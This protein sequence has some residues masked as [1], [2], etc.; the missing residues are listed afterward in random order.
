MKI[1]LMDL[2]AQYMSL[3]S[4][5]KDAVCRV[6]DSGK[7][8]LGPEVAAL[9]QEIADY[10]GTRYAIGVGNGT[11]ALVL[12]LDGCGIGPGDE[13]ITTSYSFFATAEAVSRVGAKPVFADIDEDTYNIDTVQIEARITERT[14]AILPV[15]LFGQMAAMDEITEIARRHNLIVIEDACQAI[16]ASYKGRKAGSW[17]DAGCFSFFPSKNLGGYGDGG[18]I[19]TDNDDLA[20]RLKMLRTHGSRRKYFNELVGYNSRLDEMQAAILRVKLRRLDAWNLAR[21]QKAEIYNQFLNQ[22]GLKLPKV[23]NDADHVY[24]LYIIAH[25]ARTQIIE[26]LTQRGVACGIYYPLPLHLLEVYK[27]CIPANALPAA[28]KVSLETFA[29]PMFPEMTTNQQNYVA[30]NIKAIM[31]ALQD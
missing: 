23:M 7:Y 22:L 31:E 8:I 11:D 15:H 24:H 10:C 16:G 18:M 1:P 26:A 20:G 29:V 13:V 6:F 19:T 3:E 5:I 12:C 21:R 27:N 14:K 4:E 9:E 30:K 17:G 25:P 28:E 2:H